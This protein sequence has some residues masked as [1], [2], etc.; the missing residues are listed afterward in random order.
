METQNTNFRNIIA[1][2]K[3]T[4]IQRMRGML[5]NIKREYNL[6]DTELSKALDINEDFL[7]DFMREKYDGEVPFDFV[8]KMLAIRKANDEEVITPLADIVIDGLFSNA[9]PKE[10]LH[11]KVGELLSIIGI[12]N[13]EDIDRFIAN[14]KK[15][16]GKCHCK[17]CEDKSHKEEKPQTD[18]DREEDTF[19]GMCGCLYSKDSDG[20]TNFHIMDTKEIEEFF[21]S[22]FP[23]KD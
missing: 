7:Y 21:D 13:E 2:K 6:T 1:D 8:T 16:Y 11:D 23:D 12:E 18:S 14:A 5:F 9:K 22:I 4:A 19:G 20:K 17:D 10:T 3:K 15:G